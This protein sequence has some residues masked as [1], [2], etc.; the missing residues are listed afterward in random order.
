MAQKLGINNFEMVGLMQFL[1]YAIRK[2]LAKAE[3]LGLSSFPLLDLPLEPEHG[4]DRAHH[5]FV[6][7]ALAGIAD[8]TGPVAQGMARAVERLG[9]GA[10]ELYNAIYPAWG[11]R[12]HH[13]RGVA[14]ALHW[15]TDTRG[16]M[17]S[18]QDYVR[19]PNH[20]FGNSTEIADWFG[21]PGGHLA[22][23]SEGKN[24][25]VYQDTERLTVW[26]QHNQSLK[27]SLVFPP[28]G[29]GHQDLR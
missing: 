3:D 21:V 2:G 29:Y 22:G 1:G 19:G 11:S 15:A 14:E 16:P 5:E 8:G 12:V 28:A 13:V 27:N 4:D 20:G 23:E 25:N 18:C 9:P 24:K 17:N 7:E 26:V 6:E 10:M